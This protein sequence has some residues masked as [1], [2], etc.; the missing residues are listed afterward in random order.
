MSA[1]G[2]L[3]SPLS[4]EVAMTRVLPWE[5]VT[6]EVWERQ[7]GSLRSQTAAVLVDA[8]LSIEAMELH[9]RLDLRYAGQGYEVSVDANVSPDGLA[10]IPS[11][12]EQAYADV[13]G[14]TLKDQ[15]LEVVHWRLEA[16]SPHVKQ[17]EMRFASYDAA[18]S[19]SKGLRRAYD[20]DAG[21]YVE[22]AVM[23]RYRLVPGDRFEGPALV[24]EMESTTVVGR[25][26]QARVDERRNL[27]LEVRQ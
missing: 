7:F 18:G 15:Q 6:P 10:S 5:E 20:P 3:I 22:H 1:L 2:L 19:A 9:G 4:F 25:G 21:A 16:R 23:D 26:V 17:R 27:I 13:F 11:R 8:D 12:F 14:L 24:E